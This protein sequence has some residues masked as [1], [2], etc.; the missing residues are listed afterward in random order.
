MNTA[1]DKFPVRRQK[2]TF[3]LFADFSKKVLQNMSPKDTSF[4]PTARR[5][6]QVYQSPKRTVKGG[7]PCKKGL[8]NKKKK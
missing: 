7:S 3:Y 1:Y 4:C 6:T 2:Q 5:G 8:R